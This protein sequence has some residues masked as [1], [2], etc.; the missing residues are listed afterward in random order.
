MC[1]FLSGVTAYTGCPLKLNLLQRTGAAVVGD[2]S[3]VVT[4]AYG[5]HLLEKEPHNVVG[6][7]HSNQHNITSDCVVPNHKRLTVQCLFD[8][9][10]RYTKQ[11]ITTMNY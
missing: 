9:V 10:R 1:G 5:I 8:I 7:Y 4:I 3:F 11:H 2:H 6:Q